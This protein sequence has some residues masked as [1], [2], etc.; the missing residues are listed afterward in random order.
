MSMVTHFTEIW[1]TNRGE[2]GIDIEIPVGHPRRNIPQAVEYTCL[3][4][5]KEVWTEVTDLEVIS[6]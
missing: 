5:R 1:N 2:L 6:I 4:L 3:K